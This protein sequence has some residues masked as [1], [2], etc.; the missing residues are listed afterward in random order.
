[1]MQDHH[2]HPK[3]SWIDLYLSKQLSQHEK[4]LAVLAPDSEDDDDGEEER[5]ILAK[6]DGRPLLEYTQ[7]DHDGRSWTSAQPREEEE[8]LGLPPLDPIF[9]CVHPPRL[10]PLSSLSPLPSS[11]SLT[12]PLPET[13]DL[14][15][16][17]AALSF[18]EPAV[19]KEEDED[20]EDDKKVVK[21]PA[22]TMK[23]TMKMEK[24]TPPLVDDF[25]TI[26]RQ[27][28]RMQVD[29]RR[30]MNSLRQLEKRVVAIVTDDTKQEQLTTTG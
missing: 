26:I 4:N 23:M 10:S 29:I 19:K 24:L 18:P 1:M 9:T 7:D 20:W 14:R 28:R 17:V 2:R 27:T 13:Q 25:A 16:V 15:Q 21:G 8:E 3:K 12:P 22:K 5:C 11:S 30:L 6:D